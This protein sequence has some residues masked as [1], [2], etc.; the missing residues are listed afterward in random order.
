MKILH[1]IPSIDETSGGV[2]A[3]MQLL[4]RDLGRLVELHI[5]THKGDNERKLENCIV[6]YIPNKWLPWDNC[7]SDFLQLLDKVRPD[8]FHTNSCWMPLSAMTA[9]WAKTAG[10]KVVYT[11]HGMLEPWALQRNP[12]KKK[13]AILLFQKKGLQVSDMIHATAESEKQNLIALGWNKNVTSIANCV[14]I[15]EIQMKTSWARK[16]NILFL[17]RVHVKKGINF[18]I[19]AVAQLKDELQGYTV[20]IA[21]PGE[22]AYVNELKQLAANLGVDKMVHFVGPIYAD[23]KWPLYRTADLFVLP[24]WSENFGIVVPEALA[25]GTPVITTVG[26]PW[27]E[28]NT[29]NCGWWTEIGTDPAVEA[30]KKFL[31][32][33]ETDLEQMGRNGRKLVEDEYTSEA[34]AKQFVEMYNAL[35]NSVIAEMGGVIL[36]RL[37]LL[38]YPV[39]SHN[40]AALGRERRVAA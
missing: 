8:V 24:T 18:L 14:Q 27:E 12:W 39:T 10:Y 11:P 5:V 26:T 17:S 29:C 34:I 25:S 23:N 36:E 31:A 37:N 1:Y 4:A 22:D 13:L 15:D 33:S 20:T 7:K 30:L 2:G 38:I 35:Q 32:C 28:L 16:K 21:G 6:H 40:V 3:Y 19:E 9:Q